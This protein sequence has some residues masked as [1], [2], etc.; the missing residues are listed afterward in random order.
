MVKIKTILVLDLVLEQT[1]S[2]VYYQ[3]QTTVG[4]RVR[5]QV[6]DQ[7]LDRIYYPIYYRV[8]NQVRVQIEEELKW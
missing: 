8:R 5:N 1:M 3:T 6:Y 7:V 2:H 4:G